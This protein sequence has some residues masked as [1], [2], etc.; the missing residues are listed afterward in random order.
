MKN[1]E[2]PICLCRLLGLCPARVHHG[3]IRPA[4][5]VRTLATSSIG[6]AQFTIM[7]SG[8]LCTFIFFSFRH[9]AGGKFLDLQP[10]VD[11]PPEGKEYRIT[12]YTETATDIQAVFKLVPVVPPPRTFSKLRLINALISRNL[13]PAVR[14]WLEATGYYDLFVAAQDFR[15]DHP[16]FAAALA[17][18]LAA[19]VAY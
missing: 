14:D 8:F 5:A 11:P 15:E 10:P 9:E 1:V 7:H 2:T 13:W 18:I 16:Q 12:G 17:A 6:G 4:I 19:S 3:T